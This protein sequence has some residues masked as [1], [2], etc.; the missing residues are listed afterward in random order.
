[1]KV[2]DG[3]GNTVIEALPSKRTFNHTWGLD[4]R[5]FVDG[6]LKPGVRDD[7]LA[8]FSRFCATHGYQ[9]WRRWGKIVLF[10]SEAS[11]FTG[12][13][14]IG[15]SDFDLS[16]GI[17]YPIFR[18]ANPTMSDYTDEEIARLLTQQMHAELNDPEH[19]FEVSD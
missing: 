6:R 11:E 18:V 4:V 12:P 17:Y 9:G 19:Y 7:I 10:G 2:T 14:R 3:Q 15:N 5:L 1:M 13:G 16:L 8:Q